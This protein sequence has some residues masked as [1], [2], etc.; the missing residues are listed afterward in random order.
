MLDVLG[1]SNKI[2]DKENILKTQS[3]YSKLMSEFYEHIAIQRSSSETRRDL[4]AQHTEVSHFVFDTIVIVSKDNVDRL[5]GFISAICGLISHFAEN[6]MPLRG[7]I[8]YGD[9]SFDKESGVFLSNVFKEIN[10]LEL[11]QQWLG[12]AIS[13]S[14]EE[15]LIKHLK[16]NPEDTSKLCHV[17]KYDIPLKNDKV[18][19]GLCLNWV[20]GVPEAQKQTV[21]DYMEGDAAKQANTKSF[22]DYISTFEIE[23]YELPEIYRPAEYVIMLQM[24]DMYSMAFRNKNG[25]DVENGC[26]HIVIDPSKLPSLDAFEGSHN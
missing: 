10:N 1:M 14:C 5:G 19:E 7:A 24:G 25:E 3:K 22:I 23:K 15:Q 17:V 6:D 2:T 16:I 13:P 18:L 4:D 8:G 20:W 9:Y 12:C 11:A 26:K 21:I